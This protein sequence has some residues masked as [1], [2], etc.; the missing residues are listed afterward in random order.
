[1]CGLSGFTWSDKT[2]IKK[3]A[4][5]LAHRGPDGEGFYIDENISL[6]HRRLAVID[7]SEKARQ[8]VFNEDSSLAVICNGEIYNY[9]ELRQ[10]LISK[11][12][13]FYTQSDTEV[14][15]HLFEEY[16]TDS[17]KL[18]DGMFAFVLYDKKT[19]ELFLV[20]DHLAIKNIYYSFWKGGLIF[21]SEYKAILES[22]GIEKKINERAIQNI[23]TYGYN[24]DTET[25]FSGIRLLEP[26]SFLHWHNNKA[27]VEVYHQ[28]RKQ[29]FGYSEKD[30]LTLLEKS[31]SK[32][33]ISDVPIAVVTSGGLDSSIVTAFAKKYKPDIKIFSIGF[34]RQD[35]E[36]YY[37]RLLAKELKLDYTEILLEDFDINS[38]IRNILYHQETPQDTGSMLPKWY[39]AQEISQRGYKVVL[40]G[41]GADESWF[42]YTRHAGMYG[43]LNQ[44]K[45]AEANLNN[46]YFEKYIMKQSGDPWLFNKFLEEKPWYGICSFFDLFHEIPYYHNIRLDKMFMAWG[47]EYRLP[48]LDKELVQFSLNI[49]LEEKLKN[50]ERKYLL[51]SA[52]KGILPEEILRRPKQPLKIPQVIEDR[53]RWQ[54]YIIG[55]WKEAF[56]FRAEEILKTKSKWPA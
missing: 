32:M 18:L 5:I 25:P 52:M 50:G 40:G 29:G 7:L 27:R 16:H 30:L 28:F 15:P 38:D 17:F 9:Q 55:V 24:P 37:S 22:G 4:D 1:M 49:P 13:K 53:I 42:G 20:V 39:L 35:N 56:G 54:G 8:P 2:L 43:M 26:G 3:M 10:S 19:N 44:D 11:G 34:T 41:S 33:L 48:F 23:I 14:I 12:H 46:L 6:G 36:F 51:R 21:A 47:I 31:V 45:A